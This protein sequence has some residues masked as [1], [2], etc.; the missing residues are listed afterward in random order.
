MT[1]PRAEPPFVVNGVH[2]LPVIHERLEFADLV[3]RSMA[4]LA[5]DG[6]VV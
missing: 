3:R 5:P 2:V 1:E 4:D 6:V